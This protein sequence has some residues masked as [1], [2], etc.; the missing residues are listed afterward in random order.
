MKNR[1]VVFV[2]ALMLVVGLVIAGCAAPAPTPTPTPTPAPVKPIELS[3]SFEWGQE[4]VVYQQ[5]WKPWIAELEKRTGG[6]VKIVPYFLSSLNPLPEAYPAVKTGVADIVELNFNVVPGM[7]PMQEVFCQTLPSTPW[8]KWSRVHWEL[9]NKFPQF[10]AEMPG[11]KVLFC[12]SIGPASIGMLKKPIHSLA[13]VKGTKI[14]SIGKPGVD[15]LTAL[16]FTVVEKY[17]PE[18]Y[19][20]L[21]KGVTDSVGLCKEAFYYEFGMAPLIKYV[22]EMYFGGTNFVAVMNMDK[23]NSLPPDIQ[24]VF[25]D[26]GGEYAADLFD[27]ACDQAVRVDGPKMMEDKYGTEFIALSPEELAKWDALVRPVHEAYLAGLEAKGLPAKEVYE[28]CY[29]L[30][31][32]YKW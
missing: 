21:E 12:H 2:F 32:K 26:I 24:K 27:Q 20:T 8:T 4:G 15:Q 23:F 1:V 5:E 29:Q 3:L 22:I 6:R 14:M 30:A 17:P 28:E 18:F 19:T 16:G 9:S 25:E 31:K 7:F 11:V 10:A 13:D